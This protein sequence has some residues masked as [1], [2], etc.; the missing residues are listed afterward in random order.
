ME[1]PNSGALWT[2]TQ[3]RNDRA[4]DM[5]GDITIEKDLLMTLMNEAQGE[6]SV[7][8]KLDGWR[9]KDKNGNAMVSIM[10]RSLSHLPLPVLM[11]SRNF[12]M[13]RS[14]PV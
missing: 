2:S 8:I 5:Y 4:P 6:A 3:K 9:R 7:K 14:S 13:S 10:P 12:C 11:S 1:Y